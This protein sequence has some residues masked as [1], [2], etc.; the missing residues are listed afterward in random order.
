MDFSDNFRGIT[1]SLVS[2]QKEE[3]AYKNKVEQNSFNLSEG[4]KTLLGI[5]EKQQIKH[6][7]SQE[8]QKKYDA[9]DVADR[10]MKNLIQQESGGKHTDEGGNLITSPIGAR[11]ITQIMPATAKNPGY[12]ITPL[13]NNSKEEYLRF[14]K[15]Y[16]EKMIYIFDNTEQGIAAYNAG[17]AA[18]HRAI[19]KAGRTGRDWKDFIPK[20]TKDYLNKVHPDE[21]K[22]PITSVLGVRG[23]L[24]TPTSILDMAIDR[25]THGEAILTGKPI[26]ASLKEQ[27]KNPDLGD[28]LPGGGAVG[29]IKQAG[30]GILHMPTSVLKT[31]R[32]IN[33]NIVPKSKEELLAVT[34]SIKQE[35]IKNPIIVTVS[36]K[37]GR[38]YIT[39]GNTRVTVADNLNLPNVP[40]KLEK[41]SVPFTKEQLQ[42]SRPI[43]EL[44]ISLKDI[45]E[46]QITKEVIEDRKE[47]IKLL[48]TTFITK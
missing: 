34:N 20:E 16:L 42:K 41:T 22:L 45:P 44:G 23:K 11:G 2:L 6:E 18:I 5:E 17:P 15:E 37:D 28:F 9:R 7:V 38:A 27:M 46:K 24:D 8:T 35:G 12:G 30:S 48:N 1:S 10:V 25:F 36:T 21:Q 29:I 19:S 39:N 32:D 26:V 40:V 4:F 47:L 3:E 13:K 33:R 31:I 14:G 43:E